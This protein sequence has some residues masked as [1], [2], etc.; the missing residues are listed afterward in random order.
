MQYGVICHKALVYFS[1]HY[2]LEP[3]EEQHPFE[4]LAVSQKKVLKSEAA[5]NNN[6]L[7]SSAEAHY[8][9]PNAI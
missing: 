8:I 4:Q 3:F 1:Q 5:I 7:F 2:L 9:E 6:I